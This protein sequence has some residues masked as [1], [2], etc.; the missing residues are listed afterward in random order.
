M[1]QT[2]PAP[3]EHTT[4]LEF[5]TAHYTFQMSVK[6]IID[7]YVDFYVIVGNAENPCL[8][9]HIRHKYLKH[10]ERYKQYEYSAKLIKINAL[11]ECAMNDLTNDYISKYSFGKEMLDAFIFF[12]NCQFQEIKTV[13]LDDT[14]Y[15]PCN[16]TA[17]DTLDLLSYS[18]ALHKKTWYE[19]QLNAYFL[20]IEKYEVYRNQVEVY[21]SK[22]TKQN[23]SFSSFLEI[24]QKNGNIF[25]LDLLLRNREE[26]EILFVQSETLPDFFKKL[27]KTI[28]RENKCKFFYGW[29]FHFISSQIQFER[30][31]CFDL[32]PKIS[33]IHKN[34]VLNVGKQTRRR[35]R[36]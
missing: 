11:E 29:L 30:S 16:R 12:V 18:I 6:T 14:S 34:N 1:S 28:S 32:F 36:K 22:E 2:L 17:N 3:T 25:A 31:W 13:K 7:N 23:M 19:E 20:P 21:A 5:K 10:N 4:F 35:A 24:I 15:I 8:E 33:I 27:N 9:A 26:Y